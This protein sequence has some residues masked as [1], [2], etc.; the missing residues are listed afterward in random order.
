MNVCVKVVNVAA[1][2]GP[3]TRNSAL[4]LVTFTVF[5]EGVGSSFCGGCLDW[6]RIT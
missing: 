5:R 3:E 6:S 4:R 2:V 1:A